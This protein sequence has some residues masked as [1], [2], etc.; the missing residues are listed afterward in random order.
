M[1]ARFTRPSTVRAD[2]GQR[3]LIVF[4]KAPS[5]GEV[6]TRL[7]PAWSADDACQLY[8]CLVMDTLELVR[9]L[10]GIHLAIAYAAND[11]FPDLAW[12]GSHH[13]MFLQ[14]GSTLGERLVHAFQWAFEQG[15]DRVVVLGSDAP[16]LS[17]QWIAQAFE[18]L[19]RSDV[20]LGPTVDGG[21]HLL[22]LTRLIPELFDGMPWST[23]R[24]LRRTLEQI[25]R[26]HLAV[27]CL[28]PIADLDTPADVQRYVAEVARHPQESQT[29]RYLTQRLATR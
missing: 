17:R 27:R 8:R 7:L 16:D 1:T 18:S 6:K 11:T 21:Y 20:V 25:E 19:D 4:V 14:H 26:L 12:L 3:W 28:E 22:G 13:A 24:L 29:A 2:Q 15:A 10:P 9:S 23:P 5:P